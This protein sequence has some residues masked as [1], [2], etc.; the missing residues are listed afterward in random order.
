MI[1]FDYVLWDAEDCAVYFKISKDLFLRKKRHQPGF[2]SPVSGDN[3][4]PRWSAKQ[5][6]EWAVSGKFTRNLRAA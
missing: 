1:P 2:P 3:E 6:A 4:L 5:V